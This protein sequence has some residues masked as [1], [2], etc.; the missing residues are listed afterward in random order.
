MF[1]NFSG[2]EWARIVTRARA[3]RMVRLETDAAM[4]AYPCEDATEVP[5]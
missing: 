2:V 5:S 1:M 4:K 3:A